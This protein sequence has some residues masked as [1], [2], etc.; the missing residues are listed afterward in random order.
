MKRPENEMKYFKSIE[1]KETGLK[2]CYMTPLSTCV[3][4]CDL[5]HTIKEILEQ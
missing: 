4:N 3:F 2:K 1:Q 5:T